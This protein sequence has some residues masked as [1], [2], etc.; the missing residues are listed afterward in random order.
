MRHETAA[1]S[2]LNWRE[3]SFKLHDDDDDEEK[4]LMYDMGEEKFEIQCMD[5]KVNLGLIFR[6]FLRVFLISS[7]SWH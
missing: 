2:P 3:R 1:A 4:S 5:G 7:E 6:L